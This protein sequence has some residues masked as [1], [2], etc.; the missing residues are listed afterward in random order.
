LVNLHVPILALKPKKLLLLRGLSRIFEE[1]LAIA[2]ITHK[3]LR[4]AEGLVFVHV[5]AGEFL[6]DKRNFGASDL[7]FLN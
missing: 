7:K 3:V 4:N 2:I 6:V 1:R 5:E